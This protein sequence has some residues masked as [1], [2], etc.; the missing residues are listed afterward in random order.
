M[1]KSPSG[2]YKTVKTEHKAFHGRKG[3][4]SVGVGVSPAAAKGSSKKGDSRSK[5]SMRPIS[6][7][8]GC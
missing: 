3:G 8:K 2:G 7:Q 1:A 5:S 6:P 4:G